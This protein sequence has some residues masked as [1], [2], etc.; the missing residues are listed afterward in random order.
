[1][2][3]GA[4]ARAPRA[5]IVKRSLTISGH[6]TSVSLE[7]AF[8]RRLKALAART[9]ALAQRADRRNRRFAR[10]T[11][12]SPRRFV[13]SCSKARFSR[14]RSRSDR[15]VDPPWAWP[16]EA[17]AAKRSRSSARRGRGLRRASTARGGGAAER[18][19]A[20]AGAARLLLLLA[21]LEPF[22][23]DALAV[24]LGLDS[25]LFGLIGR[26]FRF[27]LTH[28]LL[29][30]QAPIEERPL[31]DVGL[32]R[33]D[34]IALAGDRLRREPGGESRRVDLA[35]RGVER[36]GHRDGDARRR[37]APELAAC[38]L[39]ERRADRQDSASAGRNRRWPKR[40]RPAAA[41]IERADVDDA[42]V[43]QPPA[44]SRRQDVIGRRSSSTPSACA[45][46]VSS[47]R[48]S[49]A[50]AVART[51]PSASGS[52]R[53]IADAGGLDLSL[54]DQSRDER[55]RALPRAGEG[56]RG[57]E[58]AAQAGAIHGDRRRAKLARSASP[59]P[60]SRRSVRRPE[61]R[62]PATSIA[63]SSISNRP[64]SIVSR[65][66]ASS[67]L[68]RVDDVERADLQ[69]RRRVAADRCSGGAKFAVRP[70]RAG[71]GRLRRAQ[72]QAE[73][74]RRGS[75]DR[76]KARRRSAPSARP[77][78]R[79]RS[80]ARARRPDR[81]TRPRSARPPDASAVVP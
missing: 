2:T 51:R 76:A 1:M 74:R 68:Q 58:A 40:G 73:Q 56:E 71:P 23:L 45:T 41:T 3:S 57:V 17:A 52:R 11:P 7:D 63:N 33:G 5:A 34:S 38:G 60:P 55:A 24:L 44:P 72:R 21:R 31:A 10:T 67:R 8:W 54:P 22:V 26:Q 75:R 6:R 13:S 35:H 37:P 29:R 70:F 15:F 14:A 78:V 30:L 16:A 69:P 81:P 64:R 27:A 25:R 19:I 46:L 53:G 65:A 12:T 42:G 43:Q 50:C 32:E 61:A 36:S 59:P 79:P 49:G 48:A 77:A 28:E 80:T 9:R 39:G 4:G 47:M 62:A 20:G 18:V 66:V